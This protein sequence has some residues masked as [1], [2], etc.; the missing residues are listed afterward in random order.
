MGLCK[1]EKYT[2]VMALH[3]TSFIEEGNSIYILEDSRLRKITSSQISSIHSTQNK[4]T[5]SY[6]DGSEEEV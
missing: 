4:R 1:T 2:I 3:H 6:K 5:S